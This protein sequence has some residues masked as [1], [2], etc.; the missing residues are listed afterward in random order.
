MLTDL[1]LRD[2]GLA[3]ALL[4]FNVGVEIGQIVIVL[5]FMPIAFLLR[6]SAT[7]KWAVFRGGSVAV[8]VISAAWFYER[9]FNADLGLPL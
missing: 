9:A 1:G 2:G 8:L 4:G 6:A 3:V 5:A 7:Y